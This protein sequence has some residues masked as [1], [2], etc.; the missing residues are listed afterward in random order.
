MKKLLLIMFCLA[1]ISTLDAGHFA[2]RNNK[3]SIKY[4][5]MWQCPYCH[6]H[7]PIPEPCQNPDCPSKFSLETMETEECANNAIK[8]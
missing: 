2:R 6:K 8:S 5:K 7:W 3:I 4:Q 1:S